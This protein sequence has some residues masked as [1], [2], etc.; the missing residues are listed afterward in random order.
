MYQVKDNTITQPN[1]VK[2]FDI[3]LKKKNFVALLNNSI[4]GINGCTSVLNTLA[5]E[6]SAH[7]D[8]GLKKAIN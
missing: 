1:C 3:Q 7:I 8:V 5:T 2:A 6:I 4:Y